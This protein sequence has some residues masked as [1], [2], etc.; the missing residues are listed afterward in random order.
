MRLLLSQF[1]VY[2]DWK[3][4]KGNTKMQ[5]F[6]TELLN[7]PILL[8]IMLMFFMGFVGMTYEFILRLCGKSPFLPNQQNVEDEG[9]NEPP[10][11]ANVPKP[12]QPP[13]DTL[14]AANEIPD[15]VEEVDNEDGTF[16][17]EFT[18][19]NKELN[20]VEYTLNPEHESMKEGTH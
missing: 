1:G 7:H 8:V 19:P 16:T 5:S 3:P 4:N 6:C 14:N 18:Y 2:Y 15:G 17:V 20:D 12:P 10:E 9:N 13:K 11:P